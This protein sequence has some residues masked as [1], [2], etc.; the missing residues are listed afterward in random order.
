MKSEKQLKAMTENKILQ[1]NINENRKKTMAGVTKS[2]ICE[3]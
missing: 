1:R 3:N 2:G